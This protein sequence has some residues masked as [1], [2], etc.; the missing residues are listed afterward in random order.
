MDTSFNSNQDRLKGKKALVTGGSKGIGREVVLSL[1]ASGVNVAIASRHPLENLT[2]SEASIVKAYSVDFAELDS[3][4]IKVTEIINDLQG[5]DILINSAGM[6]YTAEIIDTSLDDWQRVINLNLTSVFECIRAVLP[7]MRS[8]HSGT[9]INIASIAAKRAFPTWGAYSASKFGLLGLTQALEAEERSHGI[10][11][12]SICPGSVDTP[13]W[14]TLL[15]EVAA[16]FDRKSMLDAKTVAEA[17]VFMLSLPANATI[18]DLVL[19]PSL[20]TL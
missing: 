15:P 1:V 14:D 4:S 7:T 13:L 10:K 8:Q 20:G 11:V 12:M 16:N 5:L 9:I 18:Q 2:E 17:I 3:I 6:A 19:M